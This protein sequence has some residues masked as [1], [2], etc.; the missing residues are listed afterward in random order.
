MAAGLNSLDVFCSVC[1]YRKIWNAVLSAFMEFLTCFM[2]QWFMINVSALDYVWRFLQVVCWIGVYFFTSI[3][4]FFLF[5]S[6]STALQTAFTIISVFSLIT[7]LSVSCGFATTLPYVITSCCVLF[8]EPSSP[9]T[10]NCA[11]FML[12]TALELP[13]NLFLL[14]HNHKPARYYLNHRWPAS[15]PHVAHRTPF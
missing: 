10:Y 15:G 2:Q 7:K 1:Y 4:A 8:T 3:H 14:I 5:R 9:K 13:S 11:I 6:W 12:P